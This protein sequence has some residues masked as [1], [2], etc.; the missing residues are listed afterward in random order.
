MC[1]QEN[2]YR[3]RAAPRLERAVRTSLFRRSYRRGRLESRPHGCAALHSRGARCTGGAF[4][5]WDAR[6]HRRKRTWR[7][8]PGNRHGLRSGT[9]R[10]SARGRRRARR[11]RNNQTCERDRAPVPVI[12][13]ASRPSPGRSFGRI[14][15]D[16]RTALASASHSTLSSPSDFFDCAK[17]NR[18]L[19]S[20]LNRIRCESSKIILNR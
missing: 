16:R 7:R 12:A 11:T 19:H 20:R 6:R 3:E 9:T 18:H 10:I 17:L 4:R 5:S 2:R 13:L 14:R 1:A 8:E 15:A